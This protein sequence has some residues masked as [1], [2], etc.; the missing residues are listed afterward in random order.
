MFCFFFLKI[1][2]LVGE[3]ILIEKGKNFLFLVLF[4]F[5]ILIDVRKINVFFICVK[6][7]LEDFL[8]VLKVVF[9]FIKEC[10]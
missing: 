5:E 4:I 7:L 2:I 3:V 6:K 10:V 1:E 9:E 8:Y